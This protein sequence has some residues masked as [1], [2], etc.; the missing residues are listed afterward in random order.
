MADPSWLT[1]SSHGVQTLLRHDDLAVDEIDVYHG[2]LRW[3]DARLEAKTMVTPSLRRTALGDVFK[4]IR[5]PLMV[6]F[7]SQF[8]MTH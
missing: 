8:M 1:L 5:F 3:A 4:Y 2:V 6:L 7:Y